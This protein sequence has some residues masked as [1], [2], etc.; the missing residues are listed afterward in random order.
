[1]LKLKKWGWLTD[2]WKPSDHVCE[3]GESYISSGT[4]IIGK[5]NPCV[6][7]VITYSL[8][9]INYWEITQKSLGNHSVVYTPPPILEIPVGFWLGYRIP[10]KFRWD[11]GWIPVG[12]RLGSWIPGGFWLDSSGIPVLELYL[13][14]TMFLYL[15]QQYTLFCLKT[16]I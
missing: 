14:V 11:S 1:M 10:G 4:L 12:F 15:L 5:Y 16:E 3:T 8:N 13:T 7:Q 9:T 6:W 2:T